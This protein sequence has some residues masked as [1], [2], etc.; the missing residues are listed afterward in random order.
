MSMAVN[1]TIE[2]DV[3]WWSD[4]GRVLHKDPNC[5]P[6]ARARARAIAALR[7]G[8][9][10]RCIVIRSFDFRAA[11]TVDSVYPPERMMLCKLCGS[12]H[13]NDTE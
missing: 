6:F 8:C 12:A 1:P 2:P 11:S 5:P 10:A 7:L 3:V 9:F 13:R 4:L